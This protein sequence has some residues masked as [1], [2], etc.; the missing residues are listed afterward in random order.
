MEKYKVI[1]IQEEEIKEFP[2]Q[3][4]FNDD[5]EIAVEEAE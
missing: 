3:T 2:E 1:S 4:T 5:Q